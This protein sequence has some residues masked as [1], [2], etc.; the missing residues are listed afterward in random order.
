MTELADGTYRLVPE[1]ENESREAQVNMTEVI[2]D[3]NQSSEYQLTN[4]AQEGKPQCMILVFQLM[5]LLFFCSFL[6]MYLS[7]WD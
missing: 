4:T 1:P 7:S 5:Q 2:E 6:P 3:L